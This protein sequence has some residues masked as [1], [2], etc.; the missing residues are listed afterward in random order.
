MRARSLQLLV[1]RNEVF[2]WSPR[3]Q[4]RPRVDPTLSDLHPVVRAAEVLRYSFSKFEYWI[5]PGGHVREVMRLSCLLFALL[6]LPVLVL[7]PLVTLFLTQVAGWLDL[8]LSIVL[9]IAGLALA[10]VVGRALLRLVKSR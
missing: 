9:N 2:H 7:A 1:V 8:L 6:I 4:Q 3:P 10:V 5:S